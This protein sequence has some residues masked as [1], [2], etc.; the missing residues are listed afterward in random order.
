MKKRNKILE[1]LPLE[2]EGAKYVLLH[3]Q[4]FFKT[5]LEQ[6][7]SLNTQL[8]HVSVNLGDRIRN[9]AQNMKFQTAGLSRS[10]LE[11]SRRLD[12]V[13]EGISNL[14]T[15]LRDDLE[16]LRSDWGYS[17]SQKSGRSW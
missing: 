1:D 14:E 16:S 8:H 17:K 11:H 10:C 4:E 13:C 3:C 2:S 12:S 9:L 7:Q 6:Q 15:G 5:S